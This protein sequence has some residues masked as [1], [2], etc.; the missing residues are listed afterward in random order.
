MRIGHRLAALAGLPLLA[1][2]LGGAGP[3]WNGTFDPD[4]KSVV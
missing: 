1:L 3:A 2:S 4:R